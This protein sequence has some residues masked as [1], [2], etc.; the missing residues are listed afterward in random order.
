MFNRK[1]FFFFTQIVFVPRSDSVS[2]LKG[3]GADAKRQ[4]Y[5]DTCQRYYLSANRRD[6]NAPAQCRELQFSVSSVIN[7]GALRKSL[8]A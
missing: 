6:P 5:D 8:I 1:T 2:I 7:G 4:L 3:A